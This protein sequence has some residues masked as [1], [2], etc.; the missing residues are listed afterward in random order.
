MSKKI[1]IH[2]DKAAPASSSY[3]QALRWEN[4]FFA[5]VVPYDREC[6]IVGDDMEEQTRQTM[7]NLKYLLEAA[8]TDFEHV[9]RVTVYG[10]EWAKNF[11]AFNKVYMEYFEEGDYPTRSSHNGDLFIHNNKQC[12][13]EMEVIAAID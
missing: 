1:Q 12:L 6:N 2:S 10:Y 4:L 9:L 7:E 3:A 8:G 5:T 11:D 13:L